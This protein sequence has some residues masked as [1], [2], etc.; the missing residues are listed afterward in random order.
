MTVAP[1]QLYQFIVE[2]SPESGSTY[3]W[4]V[5]ESASSEWRNFTEKKTALTYRLWFTVTEKM[6]NWQFRCIATN[7]SDSVT[8]EPFTV[9]IEGL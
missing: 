6:H 8:S 7:G 9:R 5:K 4:Q 2:V 1:D 3:Q